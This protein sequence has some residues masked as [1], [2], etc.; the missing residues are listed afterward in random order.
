M[1]YGLVE[2]GDAVV[3]HF[4]EALAAAADFGYVADVALELAALPVLALHGVEFEDAVLAV[5]VHFGLLG[6]VH[7]EA[8]HF[9]AV[10]DHGAEFVEAD[11]FAVELGLVVEQF[12]HFLDEGDGFVND[13]LELLDFFDAFL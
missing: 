3:E 6:D 7:Y 5:A 9:G 4:Q 11:H 12:E 10:F 2:P 8:V 13:I 1:G